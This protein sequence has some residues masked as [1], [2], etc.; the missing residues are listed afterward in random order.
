[1]GDGHVL[2]FRI[3]VDEIGKYASVTAV[4]SAILAGAGILATVAYLSAWNVPAPLIRLDPLTAALRSE[5]VLYQVAVLAA[6]V[7]GL[8]AAARRIGDR[9]GR[10]LA[11]LLAAL[12]GAYLVLDAVMGGFAGPAVTIVGGVA[13][14]VAHR[15][16]RFGP[17]VTAICFAAIA[18]VSAFQT[19]T[20][21]GRL[22]R[23]DTT[24]QTPVTLTSRAPIGGLDGGVEDGGAWQYDDLYLVFRDGEAVYVAR[25]GHGS[26]VF[27][28]PA[29]HVLSLGVGSD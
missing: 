9:R 23:D 21:S 14:F 4:G 8:D 25:T 18:L 26:A 1:M 5:T 10:L 7:F 3:D 19:G 29:M 20:E 15:R 17:R 11:S 28:V 16:L 27:L 24:W 2:S 6:I 13:L 12:L 22:I